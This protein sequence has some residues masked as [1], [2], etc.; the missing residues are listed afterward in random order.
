MLVGRCTRNFPRVVTLLFLGEGSLTFVFST[1]GLYCLILLRLRFHNSI[2][3]VN[4][5]SAIDCHL[6]QDAKCVNATTHAVAHS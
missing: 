6:R 5:E 4:C 1:I 3:Q 2:L